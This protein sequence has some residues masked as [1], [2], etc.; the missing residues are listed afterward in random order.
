MKN[1]EPTIFRGVE[2][3][4]IVGLTFSI[5]ALVNEELRIYLKTGVFGGGLH[6]SFHGVDDF[7]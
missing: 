3:A 2:C 7:A 5:Y 1:R 4:Q 6:D